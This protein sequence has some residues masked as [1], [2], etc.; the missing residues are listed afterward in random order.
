MIDAFLS[1]SSQSHGKIQFMFDVWDTIFSNNILLFYF[2]GKFRL[3]AGS[4]RGVLFS[5]HGLNFPT[6]MNHVSVTMNLLYNSL[7]VASFHLFFRFTPYVPVNS[8]NPLQM[9]F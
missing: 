6:F 7:I 9:L 5:N 3:L 8:Q 4:G 1:K 2:C